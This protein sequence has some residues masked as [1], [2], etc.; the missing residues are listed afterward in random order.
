MALG[1]RKDLP[2]LTVLF[3]S[4]ILKEN[5]PTP[6]YLTLAHLGVKNEDGSVQS[7]TCPS[8]PP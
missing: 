1:L 3:S 6:G 8:V 7:I 2:I 5:S 4:L